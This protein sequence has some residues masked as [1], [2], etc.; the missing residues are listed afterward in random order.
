MSDGQVKTDGS[1]AGLSTSPSKA[2][3]WLRFA[4]W[5]GMP[6]L[7][8]VPFIWHGVVMSGII[9]TWKVS[10]CVFGPLGWLHL[11]I[12]VSLFVRHNDKVENRL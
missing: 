5:Y 8:T 1:G 10:L 7:F 6:L 4:I 11:M 2:L 12:A 3:L 9:P